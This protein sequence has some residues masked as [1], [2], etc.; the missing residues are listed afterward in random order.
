MADKFGGGVSRVL[1]P[2]QAQFTQV[3]WQQGKPPTDAELNLMQQ[4]DT[5]W[6]QQFIMRN[7]PSGWLGNEVNT[8][9]DFVTDSSWSNWLQ[10]GRQRSGEKRSIMWAVVNGWLIPVTGTKTGTPPGSPNN[11]DTT[12]KIT[13]DPPPS[14]SGDFRSDFVFLEVWQ[15]RVPSTPSTLNKPSASAIYRYGNV[16]GGY[17]YLSDD[18]QD[19]AIGF[20]TT[21][22]VQVQYR[23]RV[24]KGLIGLA[25]YPD[26]FDPTTVKAQ[27]AAS[28]ATSY[29]FAN[30]RQE[31]GDAGLWR[32]GDGTENAL[33][34]VD[35]YV[36]A[37]PLCVVFRR[38]GVA[39]S[40][41]PSQN[42]NGGFNRNPTATDRTG[43]RTFSTTPSIASS[44]TSTA[45]TFTLASATDIPLP[46][47]P[48]SPVL[49]QIGDELMTYQAITGTTVS[50]VSRGVNGTK[51]EAHP[52]GAPVKVLSGRP[53]GLFADQIAAT[54]VLDLRHVVNPN[55]FNYATLLQS[56]LD[57]LLKGQLRANWKRSGG[58]TQ[59][60]FVAYQDRISASAAG[61]GVT[62]I[63]APDNI[64]M[65]YSDAP[66]QQKVEVICTP[67]ATAVQSPGFAQVQNLNFSLAIGA[68]VTSLASPSG[69]TPGQWTAEST[70]G[71]GNGDEITVAIAQFK[72]TVPGADGDQVRFLNEAPASGS[73]GSTN[74]TRTFT[75]TNN[76]GSVL[77]GDTLVIFTG[78]AAGSYLID[79]VN[80]N[81][82]VHV[83]EN[84]PTD[85]SVSYVIR[86]G[87]GAIEVRLDGDEA[88]LPP[89]RYKV[90]PNN[91]GPNDDITIKF[92]G[93]GSPFPSTRDVYITMHVQYGGGRGLSRRP[94]ALHN[95]L[96]Y[97][98]SA[99]LMVQQSGVNIS[100]SPLPALR[101]SW[102]L[103]W[104][105]YRNNEYKN[106]LPVTAEAYAD[107]GSKTVIL[108]PFRHVSFPTQVHALD[109]TSANPYSSPVTTGTAGVSNLTLT[110]TDSTQNFSGANVQAD[111][112]LI[113]DTGLAAGRYR[114]TGAVGATTFT[115]D[116]NIPTATGID[117]RIHH[118]QS[119]MPLKKLDGT[120]SKWTTT[121]PLGLFSG[122]TDSDA[123][124]KNFYVTLPRH[125][126]PGWGEVRVPILP[127]NGTNFHNGINYMLQSLEGL[128]TNLND[129]D[130]N[131]QYINYVNGTLSYA[132]LSTGNFSGVSTTP[133]TYNATFSFG[134]NT[135]AGLRFFTDQ[136][137]M[138]RK[139]LEL[140]PFY[141]IARLFAVYEASD[142][143]TNGSAFNPSTRASIGGGGA[144][145][146]LRQDFKG[147]TFWIEI[148]DDGDSTFVLNADVLDLTKSPTPIASFESAH[149]VIEASLFGFDR[150]AFDLSKPFRLVLSR[151]RPTGTGANTGNRATNLSNFI[152]GPSAIIPA[153][154][155]AA[156][157]ALVNYSRTPYQGD[158]WGSQTSY[159][160]IPYSAGPLSSSVAYQVQSSEIDLT[161]LTRPNQKPLEI[162]ASIGFVTTL[163]TGRLSGDIVEVNQY[164]FRNV[165]RED[166][167]NYPPSSGVAPRPPIL[168]GHLSSTLSVTNDREVSQDYL[169]CTERLPL[170]AFW[171]DYQFHGGSF[172]DTNKAPFRY[173]NSVGTGTSIS[174]LV[175]SSAEYEEV[176]VQT[177]ERSPGVPGD[178][179]VHVDGETGNYALLTN[180]RTNRGG[181]VF[182]GSGSHPGGELHAT[183]DHQEGTGRDTNLITGRAFLVRNS[184]TNVGA[185]EAS[186]G[187]ELM[188]LVVT[189]ASR[190]SNDGYTSEVIIGT[191]GTREG[192]AAADLYRIEGH[193]LVS[194]HVHYDV[195]PNTITV[196]N[197]TF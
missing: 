136:R 124:R 25:T 77:P 106:L 110:F 86:R 69:T 149:Y 60:T 20:E 104:S 84:L 187:D 12:N 34:T 141:G 121:D 138:G 39:W 94:D 35:G 101:T 54:D 131:R 192:Y 27:G 105:K 102:A 3:I 65:I 99:T 126:V 72:N 191:N 89:H 42:L 109:G 142:Y 66:V 62:K 44:M 160:D 80:G 74:G 128:N 147:P 183:Y 108:S 96:L 133:A 118:T 38:N 156:D 193:P 173:T 1:D 28:S 127:V 116:R 129:P 151:N 189:N 115:V 174:S 154:I 14:N 197:R 179:L 167:T 112:T 196:A 68:T 23:I 190:L 111:D 90:T 117:Y 55:G 158:A 103:L 92:K 175:A 153:P 31:L 10:F 119:L 73:T 81:D 140:P 95:I 36:Y 172:S 170:G 137:G 61:L 144:K 88:P 150:G 52:A 157:T 43:I 49:I 76:L 134:G 57:K 16:E 67:S 145:N 161:N 11:V 165:G 53:D 120:T 130:H 9:K 13:L 22:R 40:P 163:G 79:T 139:G 93:V 64:R 132:A 188:M 70:L 177:A 19:P 100:T 56:N 71:D 26:G 164:D 2:K 180:F 6:R 32:A 162:L 87:R 58:S 83:D 24:V 21:Q 122:T 82:S 91:P 148:D 98:P 18:I 123:N 155:S 50:G 169:G 46:A 107:V 182:L 29:T 7:T 59:G 146:L 159:V 85:S 168:P 75:D 184:V 63:D 181:S 15:A 152:A 5:D 178:T 114:I 33:G 97:N 125:L 48:T 195:D 45:T 51:A 47:S 113:I 30:M 135:F 194:N 186:A 78:P 37:I 17:S 41:D 8:S 185:N 176:E 143:K 171:K 4:L 166:L